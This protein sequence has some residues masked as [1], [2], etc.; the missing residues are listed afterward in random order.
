M[1]MDIARAQTRS[2]MWG[3]QNEARRRS[4]GGRGRGE[5]ISLSVASLVLLQALSRRVLRHPL[6]GRRGENLVSRV[7]FPC[8]PFVCL[9]YVIFY[10]LQP[11]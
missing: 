7:Q 10:R 2:R 11:T 4:L 3:T 6:R 1:T 5:D 9:E 8:P